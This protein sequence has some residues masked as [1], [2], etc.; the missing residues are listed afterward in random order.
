MPQ[1]KTDVE[2]TTAVSL[3]TKLSLGYMVAT[4]VLVLISVIAAAIW[5]IVGSASSTVPG[6]SSSAS[7]ER[8]AENN[9]FTFTAGE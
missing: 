4:G 2:T 8:P 7:L 6:A 3:G 9:S 5:T 1:Q